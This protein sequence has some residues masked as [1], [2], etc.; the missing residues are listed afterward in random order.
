[1]GLGLEII[2][3][4]IA[5]SVCE[6]ETPP[7]IFYGKKYEKGILLKQMEPLIFFLFFKMK[8]LVSQVEANIF[9]PIRMKYYFS[10]FE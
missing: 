9:F 6:K 2:S 8:N 1:M 10:Y 7:T 3:A 5:I 4:Y